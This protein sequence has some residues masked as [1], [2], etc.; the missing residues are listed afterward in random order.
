MIYLQLSIPIK[1]L[2]QS[3][4]AEEYIDCTSAEE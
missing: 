1:Y 4:G 3:A 2:S